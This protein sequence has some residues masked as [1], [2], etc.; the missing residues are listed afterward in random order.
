MPAYSGSALYI[1]WVYSGGTV[2]FN[3][4]FKTFNHTPSISLY[5]ETA[6]ADAHVA[7]VNGVKSD[8]MALTYIDQA[9]GTA[10]MTSLAEGTSG[11]LTWGPEGTATGKRKFT[12]AAIAMGAQLTQPYNNVVEI[13]TT[14]TG[15]GSRTGSTY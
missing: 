14:W 11:T 9:A 13:S 7:F 8:Q 3:T 2:V 10:A 1:Q 15:N 6:G 12:I 5:E 4:D